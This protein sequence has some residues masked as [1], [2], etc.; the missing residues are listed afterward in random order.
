MTNAEYLS[1][2]GWVLLLCCMILCF[3]RAVLLCYKLF[4]YVMF[5][6]L[7]SQA[8]GMFIVPWQLAKP[9]S[10]LSI[11][12]TRASLTA[13]FLEVRIGRRHPAIHDPPTHQSF[14][15]SYQLSLLSGLPSNYF[16]PTTYCSR[17]GTLVRD[18]H[19]RESLPQLWVH[20]TGAAFR[21]RF[22]IH[23][24]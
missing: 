14:C 18:P 16:L 6:L 13:T 4:C 7:G 17:N 20:Q 15:S 23:Q 12:H 3:V 10:V 2:F 22:F 5:L 8:S 19:P 21:F 24:V 1:T 11:Y 9:V